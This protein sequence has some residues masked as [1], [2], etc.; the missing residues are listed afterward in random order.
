M[1][2]KWFEDNKDLGSVI[3][4]L[5]AAFI[6][7]V[8]G[9]AKVSSGNA[10]FT[11]MLDGLGFPLPGVLAWV[12]ALIELL[13]GIAIL[14][15]YMTRYAS[16]LASIIMIVAILMVNINTGGFEKPLLVLVSCLGLLFYGPGRWAVE[17]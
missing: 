4:R 6:L 3:F 8:A 15:G 16:V 7:I 14:I 12:V 5:A 9:W 13:G 17:K 2:W 10:M 11:G 1:N